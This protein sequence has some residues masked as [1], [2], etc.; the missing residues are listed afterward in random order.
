MRVKLGSDYIKFRCHIIQNPCKAG[1]KSF[2]RNIIKKCQIDA[3][4]LGE[5]LVQ[6]IAGVDIGYIPLA[7]CRA[8]RSAMHC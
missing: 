5:I 6:M 2:Q 1:Q 7:R 4:A 3:N 8:A